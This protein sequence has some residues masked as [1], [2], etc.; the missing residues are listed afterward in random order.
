M[1]K[2]ER[3]RIQARRDECTVE[4]SS[5]GGAL[6]EV[7]RR[8]GP[9]ALILGVEAARASGQVRVRAAAGTAREAARLQPSTPSAAP[10]AAFVG[11][12]GAGKTTTI[13]K[14]AARLAGDRGLR[15]RLVSLDD[16]R[17]AGATQLM[18]FAELL[19]LDFALGGARLA[20]SAAPALIDTPGVMP[21][22]AKRIAELA[23]R[24]ETL[25]PREVHLVLPAT[26]DRRFAAQVARA[27][28]PLRAD[29]LVLTQLD[30][31]WA[32]GRARRL[33]RTLGLRLS[34]LGTGSEVPAD[35][36]GREPGEIERYLASATT[37]HRNSSH[38]GDPDA[39]SS[40]QAA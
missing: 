2:M 3:F 18:A 19:G 28:E 14:L 40:A 24:L 26:A 13:A 6:A 8:L 17:L 27:F 7:R 32:R 16:Y 10:A 1:M 21:G 20:P 29:R 34:Y 25:A 33:A 15:V 36:V 35:L 37:T 5:L 31:P 9:D 38:E 22:E 4:S 11:P 39:A 12:T 30:Q 23:R